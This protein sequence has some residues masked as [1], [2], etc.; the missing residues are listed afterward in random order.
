MDD[1]ALAGALELQY[2]A[3]LRMLRTAIESC[4]QELWDD[5]TEDEAPFWQQ[6]MHAVFYTRLYLCVSDSTPDAIQNAENAMRLVGEPMRDWSVQE[7]SRLGHTMWALMCTTSRPTR[8][9][10]RD[11][12][13]EQMQLIEAA[14]RSAMARI[15][16]GQTSGPS[17]MSWMR[18]SPLDLLLYNL[19]HAQHH[20]ARLHSLLGRRA[21]LL[22]KWS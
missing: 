16:N 12:L 6:A 7:V 20:T 14:C 22:L 9:A 15:A 5:R 8:T 2:A 17:P 18:G 4:P 10:S 3:V 1:Q 19:R 13:L 11:E 21:K